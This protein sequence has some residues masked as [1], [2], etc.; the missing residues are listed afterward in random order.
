MRSIQHTLRASITWPPTRRPCT[1]TVCWTLPG[2]CFRRETRNRVP[3]RNQPSCLSLVSMQ[4]P[5]RAH[6]L[7]QRYRM[8]VQRCP[9]GRMLR[10]EAF[11]RRLH[12]VSVQLDHL[13]FRALQ[14]KTKNKKTTKTTT[15]VR[16]GG[17]TLMGEG[18]SG[19]I[20]H[21]VCHTIRSQVALTMDLASQ[22]LPARGAFCKG[23]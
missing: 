6:L 4:P 17:G 15:T 21:N 12:P 22:T 11:L 8:T 19:C 3:K 18:K 9:Y 7:D 23:A 13:V 14:H 20:R 2:C 10:T 16:I 1:T 5:T